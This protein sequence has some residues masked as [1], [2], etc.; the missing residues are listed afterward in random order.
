MRSPSHPR[1]SPVSWPRTFE[2]KPH[3]Q[4]TNPKK[5]PWLEWVAFLKQDPDAYVHERRSARHVCAFTIETP[6]HETQLHRVHSAWQG[7][8]IQVYVA[9]KVVYEWLRRKRK[10]IFRLTYDPE[11]TADILLPPLSAPDTRIA[12]AN[13][14]TE[15][16]Q[17][18]LNTLCD[19]T[20]PEH[21]VQ[22]SVKKLL[23]ECSSLQNDTFTKR[24]LYNALCPLLFQYHFGAETKRLLLAVFE[25]FYF[26]DP[27]TFVAQATKLSDQDLEYFLNNLFSFRAIEERASPAAFF[28]AQRMRRLRQHGK[29]VTMAVKQ[30]K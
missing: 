9:N 6:G 25:R 23:T 20:P 5:H 11:S 19:R 29:N 22:R 12:H 7:D 13:Q 28:V 1:V 4:D 24:E 17:V 3:F 10:S 15:A 16:V 27:Q 30:K 2:Y 18:C 21:V 14:R 26:Q 8:T